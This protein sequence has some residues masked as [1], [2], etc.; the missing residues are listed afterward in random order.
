MHLMNAVRDHFRG[1]LGKEF[2]TLPEEVPFDLIRVDPQGKQYATWLLEVKRSTGGTD[3]VWYSDML[4]VYAWLC[5]QDQDSRSRTQAD[6]AAKG[7]L[8]IGPQSLSYLLPLLATFEDV[9]VKQNSD[10]GQVE[11]CV[12]LPS[13]QSP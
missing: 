13:P 4:R 11:V 9:E 6:I 5:D 2:K 10:G 12:R 7:L 1:L 3:M 8:H